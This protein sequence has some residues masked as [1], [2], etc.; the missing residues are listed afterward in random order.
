MELR[1][2]RP[3][4]GGGPAAARNE[5]WRAARAPLVAFTDDDCQARPGWL[6]AGLRAAR[7]NP[8][9]FVQG[10]TEPIPEGY[11]T[12]GAMEAP[13]TPAPAQATP[14]PPPP[15]PTRCGGPGGG[16]GSR[17]ATSSIRVRS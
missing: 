8:G 14:P 6:E 3:D 1:V 15:S 2:I 5:G 7:E 10:P 11:P 13:A 4:P 12:Y 9:A 16:P 17:R